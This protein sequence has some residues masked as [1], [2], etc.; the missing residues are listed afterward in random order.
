MQL[1]LNGRIA[2]VAG[3]SRRV[4]VGAA[5]ARGSQGRSS[6]HAAAPDTPAGCRRYFPDRSDVG[7]RTMR[8]PRWR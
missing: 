4:G 7:M 8:M 1:D 6:V 2:L 5:V 3:A